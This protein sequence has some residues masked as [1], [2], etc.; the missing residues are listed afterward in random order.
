MKVG[1]LVMLK[2]LH[3]EWGRFALITGVHITDIGLGQIYV[4]CDIG[5]TSIPWIKREHYTEVI[6][7]C[8]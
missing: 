1:D 5:R 2:N 4:L 3:P 8:D 7:E 6:N